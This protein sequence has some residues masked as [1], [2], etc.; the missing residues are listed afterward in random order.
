[1]QILLKCLK[2]AADYNF[3]FLQQHKS[4]SQ[5]K[6]HHLEISKMYRL[7]SHCNYNHYRLQQKYEPTKL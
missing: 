4:Q 2:F 6:L 1:M 5:Y 7:K 3:F